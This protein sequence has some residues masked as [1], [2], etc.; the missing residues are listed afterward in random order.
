MDWISVEERLPDYDEPVLTLR[1]SNYGDNAVPVVSL[2][3]ITHT[4]RRGN[5]WEMARWPGVVTYPIVHV[6]HWMP[7]P[8]PPK[9]Q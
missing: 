3:R 5:H 8:D 4:D 9:E 1:M 6:T 7:L 2:E